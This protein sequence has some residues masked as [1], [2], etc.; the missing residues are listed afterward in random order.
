MSCKRLARFIELHK[1]RPSTSS[2][3]TGQDVKWQEETVRAESPSTSSG[4]VS[5]SS[6]QALSKP[7]RLFLR[8]LLLQASHDMGRHQAVH[9]AV[10]TGDLFD[11]ARRGVEVRRAGHEEDRLD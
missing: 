4:Q 2:G 3:R 5:T 6:G 10:K 8:E 11:Q 9:V 1:G 7:E